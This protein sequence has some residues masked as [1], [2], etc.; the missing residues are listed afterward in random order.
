MHWRRLFCAIAFPL[1]LP[2]VCTNKRLICYILILCSPPH[3]FTEAGR[4][5]EEGKMFRPSSPHPK[6]LLHNEL[7][8]RREGAVC[9][10][11]YSILLGGTAN[12]SKG[13]RR[14]R[15]FLPPGLLTPPSFAYS[16][17]PL[18]SREAARGG[19]EGGEAIICH[20]MRRWTWKER[21]DG[22]KY[23][24]GEKNSPSPPL[25]TLFLR[26]RKERGRLG[27]GH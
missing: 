9:L 1:C 2:C 23:R 22:G 25:Y 17:P 8:E 11:T 5:K 27:S 6:N 16:P 7:C 19:E 21:K 3:L 20:Y 26:A 14:K 24:G 10:R 15:F 12:K 18:T 4:E 13:G